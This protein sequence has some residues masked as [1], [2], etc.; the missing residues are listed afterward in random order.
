MASREE[1]WVD[2][3]AGPLVR[4]Y[5]L[6]RGRTRSSGERL[7]IVSILV[8]SGRPVPE[9]VRLSPEQQRLLALCGRAKTLADLASEMALPLGVIEVLADDLIVLGLVEPA[10]PTPTG[11]P[12][13][14]TLRRIRDDLRAL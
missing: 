5:A 13:Q 12:D 11:G 4:P 14:E 7:D 10:P 1:R 2:E 9:R 6:T 3:A 8:G